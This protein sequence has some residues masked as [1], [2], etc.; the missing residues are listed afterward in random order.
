MEKSCLC[1]IDGIEEEINFES[2]QSETVSG[3]SGMSKVLSVGWTR[4]RGDMKIDERREW[5][6]SS[7]CYPWPMHRSACVEKMDG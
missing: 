3:Q 6:P 1:C 4:T 2:E 5:I 7:S